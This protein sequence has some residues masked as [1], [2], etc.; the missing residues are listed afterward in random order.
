MSDLTD[1]K[2]SLET[3]ADELDD[4]VQKYKCKIYIGQYID[5]LTAQSTN[6]SPDVQSYTINGRTVSRREIISMQKQ[7]DNLEARIN[8]ILYGSVS[9]ADFRI[10]GSIS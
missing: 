10:K 9:L 8:R 5:A 4:D 1:L 2:T 7:V 3:L 6:T